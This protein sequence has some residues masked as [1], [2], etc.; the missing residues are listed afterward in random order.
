MCTH[1]LSYHIRSSE[2]WSKSW[3]ARA[4]DCKL[5][6]GREPILLIFFFF[7]FSF[8]VVGLVYCLEKGMGV[9]KCFEE[10]TEFREEIALLI[11]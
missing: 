10:M 11:N 7:F 5:C 9:Y 1:K 8:V 4:Q 2:S 6:G 3:K